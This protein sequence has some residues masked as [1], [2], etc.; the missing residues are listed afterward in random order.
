[1]A[2]KNPQRVALGE[3]L[4]RARLKAGLAASEVAAELGWY[5]GKVSRVESGV[6]AIARAEADK[7]ADLYDLDEEG[8]KRLHLL[9]DAARKKE[10]PARVADFAQSYI[11][12]ERAAVAVSYYAPDLVWGPMQHHD[13]AR[14]L[15]TWA[16]TQDIEGSVADRIARRLLITRDEGPEVRLMLGEAAVWQQIGGPRTMRSQ[17]ELLLELG[18]LPNVRLR[19]LPFTVGAHRLLGV[20][21]THL[22]LTSPDISRVY[23]EGQTH[24]TYIADP[25][26]V[27]VYVEDFES[28]W[29]TALDEEESATILRRHIGN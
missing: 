24:A 4:N 11:T 6:R 19:I 9:A 8:R 5:E 22:R 2:T 15:L 13:Y 23:L 7:L 3:A 14:A 21:F 20:P 27:A 28:D 25:D 26:E 1:M 10:S 16:R 17:L 12:M 29:S 18:Q